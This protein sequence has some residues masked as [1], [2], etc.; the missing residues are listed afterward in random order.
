MT[1]FLSGCA[2]QKIVFKSAELESP[3]KQFKEFTMTDGMKLQDVLVFDYREQ[4]ESIGMARTGIFN[5]NTP[6]YLDDSFENVMKTLIR[7]NFEKRAVKF[8]VKAKHKLKIAIQ[9]LWLD[10]NANGLQ[11]ESSTCQMEAKFEFISVK[12]RQPVYIG[13]ASS[14]V[15]GTNSPFDT[16]ESNG[17]AL[18]TCVNYL[19]EKMVTDDTIKTLLKN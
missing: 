15:Q 8:D 11:P 3:L 12:T 16:T 7:K 6:I 19:V 4:K 10:E 9:K 1:F 17:P 5:T 18:V 14:N 13:N 2:I